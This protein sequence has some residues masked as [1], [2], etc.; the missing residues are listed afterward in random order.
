[1]KP[2]A[3]FTLGDGV[4]AQ[5]LHLQILPEHFPDASIHSA[6]ESCRAETSTEVGKAGWF[7]L[8]GFLALCGWG[9]V[10]GQRECATADSKGRCSDNTGLFPVEDRGDTQVE[11]EAPGHVVGVTV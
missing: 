6:L 11:G 9:A 2:L 8:S 5:I 1:M 3:S 10:R 7:L 4:L